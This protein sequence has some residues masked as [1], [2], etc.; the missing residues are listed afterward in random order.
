MSAGEGS[1][2]IAWKHKEK[3]GEMET[4][5]EG[6]C[7]RGGDKLVAW[8][9]SLSQHHRETGTAG[10][11]RAR[12]REESCMKVILL[13]APHSCEAFVSSSAAKWV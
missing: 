1:E 6:L 7:R 11:W 9:D 2:G 5:A 3:T 10:R 4:K 8:S 13:G 12:R